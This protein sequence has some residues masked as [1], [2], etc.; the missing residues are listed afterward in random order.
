[1]SGTL[2]QIRAAYA[3]KC[4]E[5]CTDD[6]VNLAKAAPTLIMSNGLMQTLA[7]FKS[8]GKDHHAAL[9][10]HI[11]GWL[12]KPDACGSFLSEPRFEAVMTGLSAGTS[13][14]YLRATQ[15]ALAILRWIRQLAAA[16]VKPGSH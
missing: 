6:Y 14:Q 11:L 3:W 12:S 9:L 16:S 7:F 13:D 8:K 2:D 15:E 10:G 1:M 5:R 4:V